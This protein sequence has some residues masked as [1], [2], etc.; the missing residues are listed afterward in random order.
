MLCSFSFVLFAQ[1]CESLKH[2]PKRR[3]HHAMAIATHTLWVCTCIYSTSNHW[4]SYHHFEVLWHLSGLVLF[5]HAIPG[6]IV[7]HNKGNS[8]HWIRKPSI[9]LQHIISS[10]DCLKDMVV[11]HSLQLESHPVAFDLSRSPYSLHKHPIR[12]PVEWTSMDMRLCMEVLFDRHVWK[13]QSACEDSHWFG[14]N[15]PRIVGLT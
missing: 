14:S 5:I 15:F 4:G 8:C 11:D 3:G 6:L 12:R 9:G 7:L 1:V 2:S 10:I 13:P